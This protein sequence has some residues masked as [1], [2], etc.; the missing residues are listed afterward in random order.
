MKTVLKS[1]INLIRKPLN[2]VSIKWSYLQA[3]SISWDYPFK[4][5]TFL[6]SQVFVHIFEGNGSALFGNM[7]WGSVFEFHVPAAFI[8]RHL[9][10]SFAYKICRNS[11]Q[12]TACEIMNYGLDITVRKLLKLRRKVNICNLNPVHVYL[13]SIRSSQ[14]IKQQKI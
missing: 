3:F 9:L 14:K 5:F 6:R 11:W 7:H 2:F 12:W 10:L 4:E 1:K 13:I 8:R